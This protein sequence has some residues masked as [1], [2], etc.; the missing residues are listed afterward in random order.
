MA[1]VVLRGGLGNQ[2]FQYAAGLHLSLKEGTRLL[3]D[4]TLLDDR[5]PRKQITYYQLGLD[6]FDVELSF[7]ALS[8]IAKRFPLPGVWM[9]LDLAKVGAYRALGR[10]DIFL[11]YYQN[12]NYFKESEQEVR[13]AF[14]FKV[15][16]EGEAVE[17]AKGDTRDRFRIASC[18]SR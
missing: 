10:H 3:L 14:T 18:P 5:F 2:M 9:G 4:T 13:K 1:I 8:R 11:G 12:E 16:L 6:V 15:P 17:I 7:T